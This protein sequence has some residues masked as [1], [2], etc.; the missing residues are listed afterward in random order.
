MQL[1]GKRVSED[2]LIRASHA[3]Q[4]V[5]D[6]HAGRPPELVA[7]KTLLKTQT[8]IAEIKTETV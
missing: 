1:V 2:L 4:S 3:F 8:D 7:E 5:T 6:W